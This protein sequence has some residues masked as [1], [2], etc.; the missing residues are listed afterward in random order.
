MQLYGPWRSSLRED[1]LVTRVVMRSGRRCKDGFRVLMPLLVVVL[2]RCGGQQV[3]EERIL[4]PLSIPQS[5]YTLNQTHSPY[6]EIPHPIH[7]YPNLSTNYKLNLIHHQYQPGNPII[8]VKIPIYTY[9][10]NQ[11]HTTHI[12]KPPSPL[13]TYIPSP[14][15]H[16][17]HKLPNPPASWESIVPLKTL[18]KSSLSLAILVDARF[19]QT[20]NPSCL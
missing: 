19:F 4:S 5:T 17:P 18:E 16:Y 12:M 6:Y 8:P 2:P 15:K 7:Q 3:S 10:L 20:L 1:A 11:L 14:T 13:S 9:K